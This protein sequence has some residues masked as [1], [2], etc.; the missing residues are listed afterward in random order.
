M[1]PMHPTGDEQRQK[2]RHRNSNPC[3]VDA[4]YPWKDQQRDDD[5]NQ[6][7]AEGND[8]RNLSVG[9]CGKKSR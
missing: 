2:F 6:R 5:K 7:S 4:E 8:G 1:R 9:Q 3:A